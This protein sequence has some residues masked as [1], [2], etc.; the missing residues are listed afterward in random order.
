MCLAKDI[1]VYRDLPSVI[2]TYFPSLYTKD[3]RNIDMLDEARPKLIEESKLKFTPSIF[4][5]VDLFYNINKN[6]ENNL[7]YLAKGIR[8]IQ[9]VVRQVY[10]LKIPTDVMFK[11]YHASKDTP[12]VKYN[13]GEGQEKL[14]RLYANKK[15]LTEQKFLIC[16]V[17]K[18]K[19]LLK[20]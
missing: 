15:V 14:I 12:F 11:I 7:E 10:S 8:S 9:L 1:L 6:S 5:G 19:I 20:R 13:P 4:E 3:I 17:P 18:L 16:H 2:H